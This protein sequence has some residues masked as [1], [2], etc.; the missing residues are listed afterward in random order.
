MILITEN[1]INNI[2]QPTS[3]NRV[4]LGEYKS[5]NTSTIYLDVTFGNTNLQSKHQLT[6][7]QMNVAD[8]GVGAVG[9]FSKFYKL[10]S[11][12]VKFFFFLIKSHWQ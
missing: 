3:Q 5:S 12:A 9:T 8:K 10:F 1:N 4:V 7:L 6:L 11:V 2:K